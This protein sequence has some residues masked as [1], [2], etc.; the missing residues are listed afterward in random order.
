ML[1]P[2]EHRRVQVVVIMKKPK[3]RVLIEIRSAEGESVFSRA[4]RVPFIGEVK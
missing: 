4:V 2:A 1:G 3:E